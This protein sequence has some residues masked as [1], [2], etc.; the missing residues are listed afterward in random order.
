M[1]PQE[2]VDTIDIPE[3][4]RHVALVDTLP[5]YSVSQWLAAVR[6]HLGVNYDRYSFRINP[7]RLQGYIDGHNEPRLS[8][9]FY[10]PLD[11]ATTVPTPED[12]PGLIFIRELSL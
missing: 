1:T 8:I 9:T 4:L 10:D 6:Q 11:K 5:L 12:N 7:I 3:T 2:F